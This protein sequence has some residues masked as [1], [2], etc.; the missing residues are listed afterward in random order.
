MDHVADFA[1]EDRKGRQFVEYEMFDAADAI[2]TIEVKS[3]REQHEMGLSVVEETSRSGD[4]L[5]F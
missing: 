2:A 3:F 5:V 1:V 4:G